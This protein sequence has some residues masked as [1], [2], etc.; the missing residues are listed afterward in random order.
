MEKVPLSKGEW[1]KIAR[2]WVW[3]VVIMLVVVVVLG[4]L[5]G[6]QCSIRGAQQNACMQQARQIAQCLFAYASDHNGKYPDGK[7]S[8]EVFQHLIDEN[9]ASDPGLFY[10]GSLR[11][12]GKIAPD[13]PHLKPENIS[14]DLTCCV[15]SSA[16]DKLPVVFLT[17][18][19]ITYQAGAVAV[20]AHPT[21]SRT[22]EDWWNG[23]PAWEPFMAVA[24]KDNTAVRMQADSDGRIP[25][26]IPADF[27]PKGKT[28]RQLTP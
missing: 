9:Y 15:D 6:P 14:F 4:V 2:F 24:Y 3:V 21:P 23:L 18:Y 26:F 27:D 17:G 28:Y 10:F 7:T 1:W 20:V 5:L 11:T 13:G 16:P 25:N 22:W 12:P 8:T 19:K